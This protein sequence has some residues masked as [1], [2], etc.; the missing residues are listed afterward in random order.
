LARGQQRHASKK[1]FDSGISGAIRVLHLDFFRDEEYHCLIL[2][3]MGANYVRFTG[4]EEEA[5][6]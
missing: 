3:N 5:D 6:W 4:Y 1:F 2:S